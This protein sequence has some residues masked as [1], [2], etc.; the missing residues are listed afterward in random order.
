MAALRGKMVS[1]GAA[2]HPRSHELSRRARESP[3]GGAGGRPG[4][5]R[6]GGQMSSAPSAATGLARPPWVSGTAGVGAGAAVVPA[7]G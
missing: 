3:I 6:G 5:R 2:T 1:C 7:A 4:G